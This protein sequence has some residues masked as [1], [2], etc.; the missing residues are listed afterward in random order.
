M[1]IKQVVI[2]VAIATFVALWITGDL[3]QF[4]TTFVNPLV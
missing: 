2:C 4:G 1:S 3:Y